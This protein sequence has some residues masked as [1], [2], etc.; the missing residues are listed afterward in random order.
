MRAGDLLRLA[1]VPEVADL[2][3]PA[4]GLAAW[5]GGVGGLLA[6]VPSAVAGAL[7]TLVV[8]RLVETPALR[9]AVVAWFLIALAVGTSAALRDLAVRSGPAA[10]LSE[11]RTAVSARVTVTSDPR[12]VQGQFA[13]SIIMRG[14]VSVLGARGSS[15]D[16]HTPVLLIADESWA[17]VEL[18][19]TMTV[20]GR[21]APSGG[22][23]VAAVL[24]PFGPPPRA[25]PPSVLWRGSAA[26]RHAIR[27]SSSVGPAPARELVPA[28]VDGDDQG[29]PDQ[30]QEEFRASG[31]T[32]LLAV[33]GTNLTLVV[34]FLLVVGRWCGVR[35]RWQYALGAAGIVGF[36]LLAR[37]EPSVVRAAAMGTVALLGMG[38]NGTG[39]GVRAIG[40]A[41]VGLLLLD[42]WL[43]TAVGFAL[44][45]LATAGILLLSPVWSRALAHWMPMWM[46]QAIAVPTAA[47]LACTPLVAAISGQVSLVAVLANLAAGPLVAPATVCG[48]LG[49][50]IGLVWSGAGMVP[51]WLACLCA[52]GIIAIADRAAGLALPAIEWGTDWIALGVLTAICAGLAVT[53]GTLLAHRSSG[54]GC[55]LLMVLVVLVPLPSPGWPPEGWVMTV[56]D[57]GQGDGIALN[58]GDGQAVL[59]DV[60]PQA[61]SMDHCLERL[62]V[63]VLPTIVLSHFHAD[64]VDGFAETV[65]GRRVGA[66]LVSGLPEPEERFAAVQAETDGRIRTPAYGE[67]QQIGDVRMQVIGP[68]PGTLLAGDPNNASLV[69]LAEIRGVRILLTGDV[70][71]DG[72]ARLAAAYPGLRVDVLK[73]PHHGSRYQEMDFLVALD[74][75]IAIA[76]VGED[77][78]Y[79]HP[80]ASTMEPLR[81]SGARVFRTDRDGDVVV[82][83]R[84]GRLRVSTGD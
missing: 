69:V 78:D 47:Q 44:S 73:I 83:L 15:Y 70:E 12:P 56:C 21:L 14:T 9:R 25:D 16:V 79:G 80:A 57:V 4:A 53:L 2:R 22:H 18:G 41:V 1:E 11:T 31:L 30:V 23:D 45:V 10:A 42:P 62:G 26:V 84:D 51:G 65:G 39:R 24:T 60:G 76:S 64:H 38:S 49:G 61:G 54:L 58:A 13:T 36:I 50:V 7:V 32:H 55:C 77:N 8:F 33:S 74:P 71:P 66:V 28:L 81:D 3:M 75:A 5:L 68:V 37:T 43:A 59:V 29:L 63:K 67:V 72:Q 34:G 46:A 6:P 27:E 40:V 17:H 20:R 82:A 19:S 52:R 35:G 48:L